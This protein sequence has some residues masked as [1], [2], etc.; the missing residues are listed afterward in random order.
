M[1]E[2]SVPSSQLPAY[3][4]S[5][6]PHVLLCKPEGFRMWRQIASRAASAKTTG[7]EQSQRIPAGCPRLD[8]KQTFSGHI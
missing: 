4:I 5:T 1:L 2:T 6:E 7:R 3:R 8:V